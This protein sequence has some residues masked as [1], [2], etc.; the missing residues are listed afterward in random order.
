MLGILCALAGRSNLKFSEYIERTTYRFASIALAIFMLVVR[1]SV[2]WI[3]A[4]HQ[5]AEISIRIFV[6]LLVTL[7]WPE[8]V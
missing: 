7:I 5:I 6:R 4:A 1:N 8:R 2:P 3:I